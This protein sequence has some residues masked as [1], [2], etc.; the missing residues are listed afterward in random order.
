MISFY[1]EFSQRLQS[2]APLPQ[3]SNPPACFLNQ[4]ASALTA[5]LFPQ[6]RGIGQFAAI[7]VFSHLFSYSFPFAADVQ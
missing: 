4:L 5:F 1:Y 3:W 6:Q 2:P 7:S